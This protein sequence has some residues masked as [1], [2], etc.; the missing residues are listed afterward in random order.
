VIESLCLEHP[1]VD[2]EVR[3]QLGEP[4]ARSLIASDHAQSPAGFGQQ[5]PAQPSNPFGAPAQ[6]AANPFGQPAASAFSAPASAP[7]FGA[8]GAPAQSAAPAFGAAPTPAFG[9]S[10]FGVSFK[11]S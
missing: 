3:K 7:S 8:F 6:P 4:H 5:S 9:A 10:A 1:Q 2:S 11:L